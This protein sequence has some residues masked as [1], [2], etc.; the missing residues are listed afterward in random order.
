MAGGLLSSTMA[1]SRKILVPLER[2][3]LVLNEAAFGFYFPDWTGKDLR[4]KGGFQR[5]CCSRFK[6]LS[7][8]I[9]PHLLKEAIITDNKAPH[10]DKVPKDFEWT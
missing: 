2:G 8:D 7:C 6:C 5:L 1:R 4:R 9:A 3:G 10:R